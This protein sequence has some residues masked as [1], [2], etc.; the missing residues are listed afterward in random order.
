MEGGKK[1]NLGL[2]VRPRTFFPK[3]VLF[4]FSKHG[5]EKNTRAKGQAGGQNGLNLANILRL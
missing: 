5:T 1:T 3:I 4:G 2:C